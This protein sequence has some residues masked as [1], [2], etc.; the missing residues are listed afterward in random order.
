[1]QRTSL[2]HHLDHIV[3]E[4]VRQGVTLAQ[5]RQEF[6]RQFIT[7]S[8]RNNDGNLGRSAKD[9]GVHRN[10]LRNKVTHLGIRTEDCLTRSNGTKR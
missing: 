10:T 3:D 6:E 1:M 9:L 4:L 5:A 7:A 2:R 8:I